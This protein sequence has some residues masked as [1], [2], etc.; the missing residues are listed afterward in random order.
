LIA[1]GYGISNFLFDIGFGLDVA[2]AG[3][4]DV[5]VEGDDAFGCGDPALGGS[6]LLIVDAGVGVAG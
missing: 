2:V 6:V 3:D 4:E 5:G 1:S